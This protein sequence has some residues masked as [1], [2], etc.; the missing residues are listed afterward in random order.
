MG[1]N[2]LIEQEYMLQKKEGYCSSEMWSLYMR[3]KFTNTLH[4]H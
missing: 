1:Q 2:T 3:D 4:L